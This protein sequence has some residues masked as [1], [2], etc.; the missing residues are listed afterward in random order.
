MLPDPRG[1]DLRAE[2]LHTHALARQAARHGGA[3]VLPADDASRSAS[4]TAEP[5]PTGHPWPP[6]PRVGPRLVPLSP[7]PS[8]AAAQV[9]ATLLGSDTDTDGLKSALARLAERNRALLDTDNGNAAM[10]AALAEQLQV[11]EAIFHRYT[12]QAAESIGIDV[13]APLQ[14][15]AFMAQAAYL[16]TAMVLAAALD[17]SKIVNPGAAGGNGPQD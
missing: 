3:V 8:S 7:E 15:I 4:L 10:L 14:K 6:L 17:A 16:R 9:L 5:R 11:L 12:L 1:V 2:M 13:K